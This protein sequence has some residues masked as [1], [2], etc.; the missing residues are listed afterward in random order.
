MKK[1]KCSEKFFL[2]SIKKKLNMPKDA[3]FQ[4]A[5]PY[6]IENEICGGGRFTTNSGGVLLC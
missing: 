1:Q 6:G 2:D 4:A 3:E 5:S